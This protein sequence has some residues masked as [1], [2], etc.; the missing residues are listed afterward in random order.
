MKFLLD[1]NVPNMCK[2]ELEA[3]GYTDIKRINDFGKGLPDNKVFEIAVKEERTIITIDTDFHSFKELHHYG[4]I[5]ISGKILDKVG[6]IVK[7][8][9]QIERNQILSKYVYENTFI[10][11]TL[12]HF[13]VGYRKKEKYKEV[14]YKYKI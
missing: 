9:R 6:I 13:V 12:R 11:I 4:I 2:K 8:L 5:S 10:R 3:Y 14:S 7:T 1:E